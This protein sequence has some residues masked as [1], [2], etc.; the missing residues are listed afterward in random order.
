LSESKQCNL[1]WWGIV[2]ILQLTNHQGKGSKLFTSVQKI[3]RFRSQ[4]IKIP[5]LKHNENH[6]LKVIL[7]EKHFANLSLRQK[8]KKCQK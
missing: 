2:V 5:A 1:G 8:I 4:K 7:R 3:S 6:Y